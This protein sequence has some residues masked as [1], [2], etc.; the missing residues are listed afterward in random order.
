MVKGD[1]CSVP[2]YDEEISE[3]TGSCDTGCSEC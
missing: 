3:P 1:C 2:Q